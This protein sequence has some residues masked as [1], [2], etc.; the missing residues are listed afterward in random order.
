MSERECV[1]EK[2][3]DR[4]RDIERESARAR[5]REREQEKAGRHL[6]LEVLAHPESDVF[7][8]RQLLPSQRMS[9]SQGY[10]ASAVGLRMR[11][12]I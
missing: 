1:R 3:R 2:E 12:P 5:E 4:E 8:G 6:D 9:A 7:R 10:E 11:G